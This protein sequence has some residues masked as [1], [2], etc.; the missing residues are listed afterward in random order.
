MS[1]Y[2]LA[3]IAQY[4]DSNILVDANL[5]I[6]LL[7]GR[8]DPELIPR[9]KGTKN[10]FAREDYE[11]LSLILERFKTISVTPN[12]LTEVNGFSNQLI[13]GRLKPRYFSVFAELIA[14]LDEVYLRSI[15]LSKTIDFIRFG[16]TDAS[17]LELARN[18][19]YLVITTDARLAVHLQ[20][21][22]LAAINFNY[23]RNYL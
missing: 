15:E 4:S 21:H 6:L 20:T 1:D 3:L 5:L 17:I 12:V 19:N 10:L 22:G 16:L 18:G 23:F 7:V 13:E 8:F 11:V 14:E 2:D 9:V